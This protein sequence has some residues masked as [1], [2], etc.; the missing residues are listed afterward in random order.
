MKAILMDPA[1]QRQVDFQA[2]HYF[3]NLRFIPGDRTL[4]AG[5]RRLTSGPLSAL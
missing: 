2:L 4:L 5:I 3:L 1:V